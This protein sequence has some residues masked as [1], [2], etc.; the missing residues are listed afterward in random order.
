MSNA[1]E[2]LNKQ[3]FDNLFD[4][5]QVLENFAKPLKENIQSSTKS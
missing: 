5:L 3:F 4:N 1:T 2:D